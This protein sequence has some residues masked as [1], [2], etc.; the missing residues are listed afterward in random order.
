MTKGWAAM[1]PTIHNQHRGILP[2]S[3]NFPSLSVMRRGAKYRV[4]Q[5]GGF[6]MHR[7]SVIYLH[8]PANVH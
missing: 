2:E 3:W 1:T 8:R 7:G 5:S 6:A 4:V